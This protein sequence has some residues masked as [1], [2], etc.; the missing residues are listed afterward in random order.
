MYRENLI[1]QGVRAI[2]VGYFNVK[3]TH[4]RK[5]LPDGST[6]IA[7]DMFPA[8][9]PVVS[10]DSL[11]LA[12]GHKRPAGTVVRIDGVHFFVGKD[13]ETFARGIEPREVNEDYCTTDKYLALLRGGLHAMAAHEGVQPGGTLVIEH[14]VV[15][16]PLNTYAKH[17]PRL[18]QITMGEHSLS[19]PGGLSRKVIVQDVLVLTQPQGALYD[20]GYSRQGDL[21]GLTLVLDVG[22]G[23]FDFL[24]GSAKKCIYARSGAYPKAMLACAHAVLEEINPA[25]KDNLGV[26]EKVD[27]AIREQHREVILDGRAFA[28]ASYMP[29]VHA[30]L[31]EAVGKMMSVVGSLADVDCVLCTGGGGKVLHDYLLAKWPERAPIIQ[32]NTEPVFANVRG[33]QI[34]GEIQHFGPAAR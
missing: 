34:R 11:A 16:L 22:G 15:G 21:D 4:G 25:W 14:L 30:V 8:L 28:M 29:K 31:D 13:V 17:K 27:R 9:A 1:V 33:F 7:T 19:E 18:I 2:D 20:A 3:F 12:E 24:L 23:T 10:A 32:L 26:I 5:K 6:V